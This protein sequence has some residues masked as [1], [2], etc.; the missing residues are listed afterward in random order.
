[1]GR[2][3]KKWDEER[4]RGQSDAEMQLEHRIKIEGERDKL[5]G[6]VADK[7]YN[8]PHFALHGAHPLNHTREWAEGKN[9]GQ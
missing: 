1:M 3:E 7:Q 4:E 5:K 9:Q 8:K 2:W 6:S